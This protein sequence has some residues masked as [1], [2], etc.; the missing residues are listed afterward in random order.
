VAGSNSYADTKRCAPRDEPSPSTVDGMCDLFE[1]CKIPS[2]FIE[3]G[4][5]GVSQSFFAQEVAGSTCIF[6][7][8]LIKDVAISDGRIVSDG[9][10]EQ[11]A[12][13][14]Q[15]AHALS[16]SQANFSWLKAGFLL[17]IQ[18]QRGSPPMPSRVRTS[19]S[20]STLIPAS[21][22]PIVEMF[23]FGAPVTVRARLQNLKGCA[24]CEDILLDPY[25]LLEVVFGE[26][27]K[28]MDQTGWAISDIFG[29]IEKASAHLL[30]SFRTA[31][32][33]ISKL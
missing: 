27:F 2:A 6:S 20:Q 18:D 31:L 30:P 21:V 7:H 28:V 32:T 1:R 17:R 25:V 33:R 3:E 13:R 19:S 12:E 24:T 5:Q 22:R 11:V 29:K 10:R 15:D 8:V 16:Q 4:L 14:T 26:M 9:T 23:C